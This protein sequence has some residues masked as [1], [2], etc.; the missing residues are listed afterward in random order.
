MVHHLPIE[1]GIDDGGDGL[2]VFECACRRYRRWHRKWRC[3]WRRFRHFV[4][5][6]AARPYIQR[7]TEWMGMI[8]VRD[9]EKRG[10]T[11][12]AIDTSII[13]KILRNDMSHPFG[14]TYNIRPMDRRRWKQRLFAVVSIASFCFGPC[15]TC[16]VNEHHSSKGGLPAG[17]HKR[18]L[19]RYLINSRIMTCGLYSRAVMAVSLLYSP[20]APAIF[21]LVDNNLIGEHQH[22]C[23]FHPG[24]IIPP[25]MHS[26]PRFR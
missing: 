24:P 3:W 10:D 18:E 23:N 12:V 6:R 1:I 9:P 17:G 21:F 26:S 4:H 20:E 5:N 16:V 15:R 7:D 14:L 13:S 8:E 19:G 2:A 11:S 22:V 25:R